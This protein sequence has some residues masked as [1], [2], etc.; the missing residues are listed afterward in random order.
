MNTIHWISKR[1]I[2]A[3][4]VGL[5]S[6]GLLPTNGAAAMKLMQKLTMVAIATFLLAP[7]YGAVTGTW[8][9]NK[10]PRPAR[11]PVAGASGSPRE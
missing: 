3:A 5:T 2:F 9:H 8:D 1:V 11:S 6:A 4:T 7:V 10:S